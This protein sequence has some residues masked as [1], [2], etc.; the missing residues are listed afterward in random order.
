MVIAPLDGQT[1][2]MRLLH[3]RRTI[4]PFYVSQVLFT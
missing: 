4:F 1:A 2:V 3:Y